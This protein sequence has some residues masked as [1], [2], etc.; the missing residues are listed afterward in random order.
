[1]ATAE[2]LYPADHGPRVDV[3]HV[4][5]P[6]GLLGAEG[7][8]LVEGLQAENVLQEVRRL[9]E[10][11]RRDADVINAAQS[12]QASVCLG[13]DMLPFAP[14]AD[15]AKV[16]SNARGCAWRAVAGLCYLQPERRGGS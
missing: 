14:V 13:H 6:V 5:H 2:L 1:M 15:T 12:R 7:A 16:S 10:V 3:E 8:H 4:E 9:I 11:R